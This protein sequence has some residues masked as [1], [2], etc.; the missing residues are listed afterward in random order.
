MSPG[1][2]PISS[3]S[4]SIWYKGFVWKGN[5]REEGEGDLASTLQGLSIRPLSRL[6][7]VL[8]ESLGAQ[9]PLQGHQLGWTA[10]LSGMNGSTSCSQPTG[11]R[12]LSLSLACCHQALLSD[13]PVTSRVYL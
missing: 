4:S 11:L 3:I 12:A 6:T 1:A 7:P 13:G 5:H 9:Q 8:D 10:A 2:P